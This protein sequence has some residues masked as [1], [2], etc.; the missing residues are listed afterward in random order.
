MMSVKKPSPQELAALDVFNW[1]VWSREKSEFDW[2]YDSTETCY[3]LE[4]RASVR[5]LDGSGIEFGPGDLVVFKKGLKCRWKIADNIRKH[6]RF[7]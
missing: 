1:P 7:E 5:A 3:I 6:Y 4:G 2:F